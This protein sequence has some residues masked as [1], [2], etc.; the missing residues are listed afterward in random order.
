[1]ISAFRSSRQQLFSLF[2]I[3]CIQVW[4]TPVVIATDV[5][6]NSIT[7]EQTNLI[8]KISGVCSGQP[9]KAKE[10][11]IND[12][13]IKGT[14]LYLLWSYTCDRTSFGTA[15]IMISK[16]SAGV[17]ATYVVA[18]DRKFYVDPNYL[19]APNF[20]DLNATG[21]GIIWVDNL[22]TPGRPKLLGK[23]FNGT[24]PSSLAEATIS[25]IATSGDCNIGNILPYSNSL[26]S[27]ITFITNNGGTET[28][29]GNIYS[30]Q[31][32]DEQWSTP[33]AISLNQQ[34]GDLYAKSNLVIDSNG[35]SYLCYVTVV[36]HPNTSNKVGVVELN[37]GVAT[38]VYSKIYSN[39]E[40]NSAHYCVMRLDQDDK[41]HL[42]VAEVAWSISGSGRS[43][44][45]ETTTYQEVVKNADTWELIP[46]SLGI[47]NADLDGSWASAYFCKQCDSRLNL[48]VSS[49]SNKI[50]IYEYGTSGNWTKVRDFNEGYDQSVNNIQE[51]WGDSTTGFTFIINNYAEELEGS[52]GYQKGHYLDLRPTFSPPGANKLLFSDSVLDVASTIYREQFTTINTRLTSRNALKIGNSILSM[53][54]DL[55]STDTPPGVILI[56]R[57][58]KEN[59]SCIN[60]G[61]S[62]A[63][64]Q[65][66]S[67]TSSFTT[68]IL[69]YE[70]SSCG[71]TPTQAVIEVKDI[72]SGT[73]QQVQIDNPTLSLQVPN[74]EAGRSFTFRVKFSNVN[75]SS[76]FT[77]FSNSI[78]AQNAPRFFIPPEV[79]PPIQ[80]A[81]EKP[82]E[83]STQVP[84]PLDN[85][86]IKLKEGAAKKLSL[87]GI[88]VFNKDEARL[89]I[90]TSK[91][92]ISAVSSIAGLK[93]FNI[94]SKMFS[95]V[96]I[97]SRSREKVKIQI[98]VGK[99][100]TDL[101]ST[102]PTSKFEITL[103]AMKFKPGRYLITLVSSSGKKEFLRILAK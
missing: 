96:S 30:T 10:T 18:L 81:T 59:P 38:E 57:V 46:N 11:R 7:S 101:G 29:A 78:V 2:L 3:I 34:V 92:S 26:G 86:E 73:T 43:A 97:K 56:E 88:N 20:I 13:L 98:T 41:P 37:N 61:Y 4:S 77:N 48:I 76:A 100:T 32:I 70:Y 50:R 23:I 52:W 80:E 19:G 33:V 74:L 12:A 72:A 27:Y 22:T 83:Q 66:L 87:L 16:K 64:P 93:N 15:S 31:F 44:R 8:E 24:D 40:E 53:W 68:A 17:W 60:S 14:N 89:A 95:E 54:E 90:D 79:I 5:F 102:T 42:L 69:N 6:Q 91:V 55:G 36:S 85:T 9:T 49:E 28:C 45:P 62:P 99:K 71:T 82:L 63:K 35:V 65:S 84:L 58:I 67:A 103:P 25:E 1:M 47:V 51:V 94:S 21:V 39:I 75:G